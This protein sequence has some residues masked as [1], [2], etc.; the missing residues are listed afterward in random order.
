MGGSH[1]DPT[2]MPGPPTL[3][4]LTAVPP[5]SSPPP[6]WCPLSWCPPHS[7]S[8]PP[9]FAPHQRS[10]LHCSLPW[11][12]PT[13]TSFPH[14]SVHCPG[15][16]HPNSLPTPIPLPLT[17]PAPMSP[18]LVSPTP[19]ASTPVSPHPGV[20]S[21]PLSPPHCPPPLPCRTTE[22]RFPA[23]SD[24]TSTAFLKQA[25]G[26]R[27]ENGGG[28]SAPQNDPSASWGQPTSQPLRDADP[29]PTQLPRMLRVGLGGC[30]PIKAAPQR[31]G[32]GLMAPK[33]G[34]ALGLHPLNLTGRAPATASLPAPTATSHQLLHLVW[35]GGEG[36]RQ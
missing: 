35:R 36:V 12:P 9:Q 18:I 19:M 28:V 15:V 33:S 26:T 11:C 29:H 6:P 5:S 24:A 34:G 20:P 27:G 21:I 2:P 32:I 25:L 13:A 31:P 7:N 16:P 10:P 4:S 17:S 22:H 8:P 30:P 23:S 3:A 1:C 14:P